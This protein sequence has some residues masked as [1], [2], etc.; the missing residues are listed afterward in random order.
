VLF[1]CVRG[2]IGRL[3]A[4]SLEVTD[5]GSTSTIWAAVGLRAGAELPVGGIFAFRLHIDGDAL[6]TRYS[7]RIGGTTTFRYPSAAAGVGLGA[8]AI[9][10]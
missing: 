2:S 9:L 5:P 3:A 1:G 6:V 4:E 7:L 10:P 8:C